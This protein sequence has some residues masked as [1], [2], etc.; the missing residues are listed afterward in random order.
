[1][2]YRSA[3]HWQ[4]AF[5]PAANGYFRQH[6]FSKPLFRR[7][8]SAYPP[9]ACFRSTRRGFSKSRPMANP[10]SPQAAG[11]TSRPRHWVTCCTPSPRLWCRR[12][13]RR[14]SSDRS[15]RA[16]SSRCTP[17]TRGSSSHG[18]HARHADHVNRETAEELTVDVFHDVWRRAAGV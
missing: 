14:R 5:R 4:P 8:Q 6:P 18:V 12:R 10:S 17:S 3:I 16:T 9:T 15:P 7:D 11:R 13:T 2:R 1:M